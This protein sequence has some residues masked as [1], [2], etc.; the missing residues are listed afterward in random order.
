MP[1]AAPGRPA[2]ACSSASAKIPHVPA[3]VRHA[4]RLADRLHAPWTALYVET[5]A[6][7]QPDRVERDRIADCLRLAEQLGGAAITVPGADIADEV[8]RLRR[9]Q[10]RHPHRHRQVDRSRWFE[11]LHGSVVHD[12]LRRAGASASLSSPATRPS[13]ERRRRRR[14]SR[15]PSTSGHPSRRLRRGGGGA[16]RW[17]A[18]SSSRRLPTSRWCFSRPSCSSPPATALAVAVRLRRQLARLQLLLSAAVYTFTIADPEN[19]VRPVLLPDRC[20]FRQQSDGA[21]RAQALIARQR[22]QITEELYA[23]AANSPASSISTTCYGRPPFRSP[24]C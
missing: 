2:S 19:V 17:L 13:A 20:R 9:G 6:R 3:L 21:D 8:D 7:H 12:L 11:L 24:R 15:R 18:L 1:S 14:G 16:R 22:A 5:R 10:Q 23:S 4:R